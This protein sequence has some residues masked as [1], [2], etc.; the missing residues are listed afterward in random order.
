[1]QAELCETARNRPGWSIGCS[2][3]TDHCHA[4]CLRHGH[5]RVASGQHIFHLAQQQFLKG[6]AVAGCRVSCWRKCECLGQRAFPTRRLGPCR[7]AG[8]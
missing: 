4:Q 7:S 3:A 1:L 8:L 2:R 6:L 5:A